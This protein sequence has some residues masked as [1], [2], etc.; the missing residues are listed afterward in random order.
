MKQPKNIPQSKVKSGHGRGLKKPPRDLAEFIRLANLVPEGKWLPPDLIPNLGSSGEINIGTTWPELLE[1]IQ[2]LPEAV[3]AEL[4]RASNVVPPPEEFARGVYSDRDLKNIFRFGAVLGHYEKIRVAYYNLRGLTQ[5]S[6]SLDPLENLLHALLYADLGYLRR[7]AY[8]PCG[9]IFY[10][11][12][13]KQ[14]GCT[15]RHSDNS[16][17]KKK[18]AEKWVD[19]VEESLARWPDFKPTLENKKILAADV[20]V[21]LK[22]CEAALEIISKKKRAQ[23]SVKGSKRP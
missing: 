9:K 20:G 7:C 15:Q 1:R 13:S 11:G 17:K 19:A 4:I 16:R 23:T 8:E 21:S 10:A 22:K 5:D 6:S 18:R 14:P 2:E 12:K 3:R